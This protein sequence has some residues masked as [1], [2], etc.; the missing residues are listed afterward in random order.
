[1]L[2]SL[3]IALIVGAFVF[4]LTGAAQKRRT[5]LAWTSSR[6][7]RTWQMYAGVSWEPGRADISFPHNAGWG[8]P[9]YQHPGTMKEFLLQCE[10]GTRKPG[11]REGIVYRQREVARR[12]FGS[13]STLIVPFESRVTYPGEPVIR[14]GECRVTDPLLGNTSYTRR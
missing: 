2:L 10:P 6:G 11:T 4:T 3:E 9:A 5:G 14:E 13:H 8:Y 7:R 1:M 12:M